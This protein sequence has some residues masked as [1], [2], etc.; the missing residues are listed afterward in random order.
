MAVRFAIKFFGGLN[1]ENSLLGDLAV[2]G[3]IEDKEDYVIK[4]FS[5][6]KLP[7]A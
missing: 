6:N 1:R 5:A 3:K 2:I 4:S 7:D